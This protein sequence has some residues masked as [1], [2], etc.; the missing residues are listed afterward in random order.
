MLGVSLLWSVWFIGSGVWG[1]WSSGFR[2]PRT[3]ARTCKP[4]AKGSLGLRDYSVKGLRS[5]AEHR[6][7][8]HIEK[9][10]EGRATVKGG[11][12]MPH[13]LVSKV[14]HWAACRV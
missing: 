1:L 14:G 9:A 7:A 11:A 6:Y 5:M 12:V 13:E 10:L 2:D 3:Q 8:A 4:V